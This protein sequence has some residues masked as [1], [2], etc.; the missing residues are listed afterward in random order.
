LVPY[1]AEIC[2]LTSEEQNVAEANFEE[3]GPIPRLCINFAKDPDLRRDYEIARRTVIS[4][5]TPQNFRNFITGAAGFLDLDGQSHTI[6]IVKCTKL[7]DLREAY[8][9]VISADVEMRV[10]ATINKMKRARP[11]RVVSHLRIRS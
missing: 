3:L 11:D 9:D 5:L 10:M 1:S 7:D 8:V 2:S 6:I 4:R